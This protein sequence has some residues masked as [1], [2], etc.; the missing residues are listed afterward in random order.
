MDPEVVKCTLNEENS[1]SIATKLEY[2]ILLSILLTLLILY[3]TVVPLCCILSSCM[4]YSI[5]T[6]K[7][8]E[9]RWQVRQCNVNCHVP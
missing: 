3:S 9:A 6:Y 1:C 8:G 5:V 2:I 7:P 4:W